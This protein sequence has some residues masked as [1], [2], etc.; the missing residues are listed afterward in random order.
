MTRAVIVRIAIWCSCLVVLAPNDIVAGTRVTPKRILVLHE[1]TVG[2]SPIRQEFAVAFIKAIRSAKMSPIEIYEETFDTISFPGPDHVRLARESLTNKYAG[3][4]IDVIVTMGVLPLTLARQVRAALGNPAIVA[5]LSQTGHIDAHDNVTGLQGGFFIN[6]T[7]DLALALRPDT[8]SI[9]VVDGS[10][11]NTDDVESEVERQVRARGGRIGLVYLRD[12]PLRNVTSRVAAAP[13]HS[14]VLFITQN[15]RTLTQPLSPFDALREIA[16]ASRVPVF[17]LVEEYVGLGSVGGYAWDFEADARRMA[18]MAVRLANGASV[19]DVPSGR[20]TYKPL[21]DWRQLQR[22]GIPESR[23]PVDSVVLFRPQPSYELYR[24]F[25]VGGMLI[26]AA[27]LALITGLVA[28]RLQRRRAEEESR[29]NEER[30]RSVVDTQSELI[31]RFLPDSTLTFV[32]DAYC[33]YWNKT[34]EELIGTKFIEPIP[35]PA[36]PAVLDRIG[37]L[38]RGMDSYEHQVNLPDGAVGW[39]HWINHAILDA[40]GN[41]VELQGVGRD[42]TDRKRAE[43]ALGQS[44]ARNSAMLRAVPDLMFVL[45]RDGTFV[46]YH[47]RD[48]TLLFAPPSTFIGRKVRDVM[49]AGLADRLMEAIELACTRHE[50]VVVE[51]ELPMGDT[52]YFEARLVR[53][54]ADRVLSMV[55]DITDARRAMQLNRELTWR[56]IASQ[57]AE[58]QRVARELHDDLGQRIALLNIEIDQIASQASTDKA[59][60]RLR[61]LSVQTGEIAS[62][63]HNLSHQLHP[64]KLQ[65][66]GL[67]DA[68]Q[69]LCVDLS[70]RQHV[71]VVFTHDIM[72]A[73]VD[74]NVSLCL[75]RITQEAL[76]NVERHSRAREAQVRLTY[77]AGSLVLQISDSGVGFDPESGRHGGLGLV[78]MRERV[79]FVRGQLEIHAS[80]GCGTRIDVRVPVSP[81]AGDSWPVVPLSEV[82]Q[83]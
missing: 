69:A 75:Y 80:S 20:N 25:V 46:D 68:L 60:A 47:A 28:Q 5:R 24:R 61:R 2:F 76:H 4:K 66:V 3:R 14:F 44:E 82:V 73:G 11:R 71:N 41:L 81:P 56:L 50:P 70:Q 37:G 23:V 17:S 1:G 6:G 67:V 9:V 53:D 27:Q 18:D 55:R 39:H 49:P 78:S 19:R 62:D 48:P 57:E 16:G 32:N 7:I 15:M 36:R 8:Q 22:W 30:Y 59:R 79:A 74:P 77:D 12:L 38:R 58:R 31:C 54:D 64:A 35:L 29:R 51:Y 52:R 26:I 10:L 13:D 43:K 33:R 83:P 42:I 72:L 63:A 45:T 65:T 34:Q 40:Y 21:L